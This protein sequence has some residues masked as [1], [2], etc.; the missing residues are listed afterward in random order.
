MEHVVIVGAGQAGGRT[1]RAL[2]EQGFE[3]AITL[4]GD[5]PLLPYERPPLSKAV[6]KGEATIDDVMLADEAAYKEHN[7]TFISDCSV[8]RLDAKARSVSL[9][10]GF[11]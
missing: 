3:G 2:R 4:I 9:G 7:I 10:D 1:A 6:L 8:D 5:E 11:F